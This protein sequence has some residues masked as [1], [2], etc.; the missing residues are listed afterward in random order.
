MLA[1]RQFERELVL[2]QLL[3]REIE[4]HRR[5]AGV[6]ANVP[7]PWVLA[8]IPS[9]EGG[10]RPASERSSRDDCHR[11]SACCRDAAKGV[12][13]AL[14]WTR[15]LMHASQREPPWA[16]RPNRNEPRRVQRRNTRRGEAK[17]SGRRIPP[18]SACHRPF[19]RACP[20]SRRT[21]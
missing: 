2:Q 5:A 4:F 14:W 19:S 8:L 13:K 16:R 20:G 9:V 3:P 15:S 17:A 7:G 21:E 6:V 12:A 11:P 1:D 18:G 10:F